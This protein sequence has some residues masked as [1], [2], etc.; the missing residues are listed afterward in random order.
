MKSR[1]AKWIFAVLSAACL[2]F[3]IGNGANTGEKSSTLSGAVREIVNGALSSA[4]L[5]VSLSEHLIRKAAHFTEYAALGLLLS[6]TAYAFLSRRWKFR[7]IWMPVAA[8]LLT[9][10]CDETIQ[11][12]TLGRSG[13]PADVLLDMSGVL[14]AAGIVSLLLRRRD[15]RLASDLPESV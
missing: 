5:T 3:I 8:C 4:G 14:L 10:V 13:S 7:Y 9:A 12:F 2:I 11:H 15:R 6:L 1:T